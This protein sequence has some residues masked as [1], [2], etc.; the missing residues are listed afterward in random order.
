VPALSLTAPTQHG[1]WCPAVAHRADPTRSRCPRSRSPRR[2]NDA[3]AARRLTEQ[4]L[5]PRRAA[6]AGI[7]Q[8]AIAAGELRAGTDVDM[9]IDL[10]VGAAIYRWLVTGQPVDADSG[11]RFV[12]AVLDPLR[13]SIS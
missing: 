6:I 7:L 13:P 10:M 1:P 12:D 8:R 9:A 5:T 11:R 4:Y 2:P 3:E